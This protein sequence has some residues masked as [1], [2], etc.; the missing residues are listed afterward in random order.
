MNALKPIFSYKNK[1]EILDLGQDYFSLPVCMSTNVDVLSN[2]G[3]N[4]STGQTDLNDSR[5]GLSWSSPRDPDVAFPAQ[6]DGDP[7]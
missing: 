1:K 4:G 3:K 5:I 2:H 7:W 6:F